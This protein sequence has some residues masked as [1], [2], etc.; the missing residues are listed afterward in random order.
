MN[1]ILSRL[2]V[3]IARLFLQPPTRRAIVAQPVKR[4]LRSCE[5]P[6]TIIHKSAL[7]A[8]QSYQTQRPNAAPDIVVIAV[9]LQPQNDGKENGRVLPLNRGAIRERCNGGPRIVQW[10]GTP[11][12]P[13]Q[14]AAYYRGEFGI[15]DHAPDVPRQWWER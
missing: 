13:E 8:V 4:P 2:H 3:F 11:A 14:I 6:A 7:S 1:G 15:I 12:T 9:N 5:E 10:D